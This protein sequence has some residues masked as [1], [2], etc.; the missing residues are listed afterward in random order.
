M[1]MQK[2]KRRLRWI[3]DFAVRGMQP[4]KKAGARR[5]S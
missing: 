1:S 5:R 2:Q 4:P 3:V